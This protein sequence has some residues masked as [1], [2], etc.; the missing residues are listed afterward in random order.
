MKESSKSVNISKRGEG[1][2][3]IL[4]ISKSSTVSMSRDEKHNNQHKEL[5]QTSVSEKRISSSKVQPSSASSLEL[6][7]KMAL[8]Y[9]LYFRTDLSAQVRKLRLT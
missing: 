6:L 8:E 3:G 7:T 1:G 5:L 4:S 9:S 2:S